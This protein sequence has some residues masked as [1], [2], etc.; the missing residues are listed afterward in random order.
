MCSHCPAGHWRWQGAL[1][2]PPHRCPLSFQTRWRRGAH[3]EHHRGP[4]PSRMQYRDKLGLKR[5]NSTIICSIIKLHCSFTQQ[6][7]NVF[8][9]LLYFTLPYPL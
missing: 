2:K 4:G 7:H 3:Q 6:Q 1:L 8:P 9:R 5:E